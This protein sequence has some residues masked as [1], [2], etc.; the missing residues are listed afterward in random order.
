MSFMPIVNYNP[1]WK[2][3]II[4]NL[5]VKGCLQLQAYQVVSTKIW[6]LLFWDNLK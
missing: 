1:M 5:L 4:E 2:E 6:V 3:E